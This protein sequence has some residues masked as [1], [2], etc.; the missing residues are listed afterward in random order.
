VERGTAYT[1]SVGC[2]IPRHTEFNGPDDAIHEF[3]VEHR[4]SAYTSDT[5]RRE[6]F[7][8]RHDP[9]VRADARHVNI[10]TVRST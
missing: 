1:S 5:S 8:S 7:R 9:T 6:A 10:E 3:I 2:E 4:P